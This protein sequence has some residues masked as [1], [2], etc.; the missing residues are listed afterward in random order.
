[1]KKLLICFLAMFVTLA[2]EA[3]NNELVLLGNIK[4]N[5]ERFTSIIVICGND[6][7]ETVQCVNR[8]RIEGL[9]LYKD[10]EVVFTNDTLCKRLFIMHQNAEDGGFLTYFFS[11]HID[12]GLNSDAAEKIGGLQYNPRQDDYQLIETYSIEE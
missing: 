12:W 2:S 1:M 11:F 10:Y 5:T 6:T 9:D 4:N 8:F 3:Q 7:V